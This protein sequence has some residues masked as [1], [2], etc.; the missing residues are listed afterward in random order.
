MTA[1]AELKPAAA[2]NRAPWFA[3]ERLDADSFEA[4]R[5]RASIE[6]CK[7]DAQVGDV[8][9]LADFPVILRADVW[10]KL[11]ALAEQLS[12]E[13][14]AAEQEILSRPDL[15]WQMGIP[16][17]ICRVLQRASKVHLT[18]AA[19]APLGRAAVLSASRARNANGADVSLHWCLHRKRQSRG[20]LCPRCSAPGDRLCGD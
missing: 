17:A 10:R 5:R 16:R 1:N 11:A 9:T 19:S 13:T 18:P 8:T 7:W 14:L 15:M 2:L 20:C 4:I 12:A 3:G 6:F